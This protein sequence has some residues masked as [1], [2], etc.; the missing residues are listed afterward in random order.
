MENVTEKERAKTISNKELEY[1]WKKV[2]KPESWK[3]I[4]GPI[5]AVHMTLDH[6]GWKWQS[7]SVM[8]N[9]RGEQIELERNSPKMLRWHIERNAKDKFREK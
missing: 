6:M 4:R 2:E 7:Y 9:E 1:A 5:G 8:I 3:E